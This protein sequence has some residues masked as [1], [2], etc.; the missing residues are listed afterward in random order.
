MHKCV[1]A[2]ITDVLLSSSESLHLRSVRDHAEATPLTLLK[3]L[4][5]LHLKRETQG[6][7]ECERETERESERDTKGKRARE[8]HPGRE[9]E[10]DMHREGE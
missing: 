5:I 10:R 1:C 4:L 6:E 9:S 2:Y 7:R 8:R 3:V